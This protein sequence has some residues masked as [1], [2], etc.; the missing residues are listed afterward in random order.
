[1]LLLGQS[2]PGIYTLCL[3]Q[4]NSP[5]PQLLARNEG[6]FIL[7]F[8]KYPIF[9]YEKRLGGVFKDCVKPIIVF[10]QG[11]HIAVGLVRWEIQMF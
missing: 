7:A 2:C 9:L 1:M 3:E 10:T 4:Q 6:Y 5:I 8:K 11:S